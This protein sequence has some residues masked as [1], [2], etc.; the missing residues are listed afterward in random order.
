M[1]QHPVGAG[2]GIVGKA[3][4]AAGRE[5]YCRLNCVGNV[6]I[7]Q[8]AV[9]L[10]RQQGRDSGYGGGVPFLRAVCGFRR[11]LG[12]RGREAQAAQHL[13]HRLTVG[14]PQ[15]AGPVGIAGGEGVAAC[16]QRVHRAQVPVVQKIAGV[17]VA[18]ALD[19]QHLLAAEQPP[20]QVLPQRDRPHRRHG[21]HGGIDQ[22]QAGGGV[23]T[24]CGLQHHR[25]A[26]DAPLGGAA[27]GVV[28]DH[29]RRTLARI[30]LLL[31]GQGVNRSRAVGCRA[32]RHAA[33]QQHSA[34]HGRTDALDPDAFMAFLS[35]TDS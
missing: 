18:A 17:Q 14:A 1:V 6:R 10:L 15:R 9:G 8:V 33:G 5:L 34:Q 30:L 26:A 31:P 2:V 32:A 4:G 23:R 29:C 21:R 35:F 24:G 7:R 28:D 3:G 19:G 25:G 11:V 13:G 12:Q 16:F 22:A 27:G 20:E